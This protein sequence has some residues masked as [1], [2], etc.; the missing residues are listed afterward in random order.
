MAKLYKKDFVEEFT[1]INIFDHS[2]GELI[3]KIHP[4]TLIYAIRS[5]LN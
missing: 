4:K 3:L 1:K 5:N 2:N